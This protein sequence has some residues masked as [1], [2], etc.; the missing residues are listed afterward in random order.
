MKEKILERRPIDCN[1]S[2]RDFIKISATVGGAA[3]VGSLPMVH[4]VL[5]AAAASETYPLSDPDRI[6]YSVCLNCHNACPMK[7]KIQDGVLVKIEGNPY[8][9]Q[10]MLVPLPETTALDEAARSDGPICPKGQAGVQ[11]LY[12]PY[13][14]RRV[15]KRTGKR[16]E[17]KWEAIDFNQAVDEIVSGGN[18]FG[19]GNIPGLEDIYKL[20]DPELANELKGDASAVARGDLTLA[21]FQ[22]KHASHMDLLVDPNHPDL[23]PVN[24][25]FVFLGGRMEHG[26]KELGK[27]FTYNGFGSTNFFLHTTICEQSHHIAYRMMS[28]NKTHMKPDIMNSEFIIYFGTSPFEANFGP[29]NLVPK[30]TTSM[31]EGNLKMAVIDPRLSKTAAKAWK[32]LAPKPGTDAAIALGMI[33]WILENERYDGAFLAAPNKDTANTNDETN[34]SNAT[35]L[36]R[37]DDMTFLKPEDA[38]LEVPVDD[39]GDPVSSY[40]VMVEGRPTLSVEDGMA[41]LFVDGEVNDI[42][43]KSSL[44]LLKDRAMERSVQEYADIAGIRSSDITLLAGEFTSHGKRAVAD[45]YRGPVQHTNGYY[46]GQAIITLNVLIGNTDWKGGLTTGGSHWHED[47]SK[48]GA[49]FPKSMVVG[50]PGGMPHWG[51]YLNRERA[52]YEK[53]TL[54]DGYPAKRPW[55]PFTSELYQNVIPSA[56]AR[57][58]YP[59][60][61]M[62]I[63]KGSPVLASPAGHAQIEML[64]DPGIIPLV[65]ACDIVVGE[66]SMY[67]DYIIPDQTFLERWG[68]PH[69]SPDVVTK[70]SKVRQPLVGPLTETTTV[71]GE[72]MPIGMDAFLIAVG[73]KLGLAG[74]GKDALGEGYDFDR[75]EHYYLAMCANLAFGDKEDG[76]EQLPAPTN[77]EMDVFR[78]AH[79]H[80]PTSIYDEDVWQAAVP[81]ELWP[82]VVT[83]IN[84]GGRYE[85][86]D[87][88]YNGD[89]MA[90]QWKGAW[91]LY[92]ANV[93]KAKHSMTGENFDGLPKVEPVLDAAGKEVNDPGYDLTLITY[94]EV[95]GGQSRTHGAHWMTAVLPENF[96]ALNSID[97]SRMGLE[98]GDEARI[99]SPT[100]DRSFNLGDGRDYEVVGRVKVMEGIRPGVAAVS[101]SYG[102]WAYGSND[103]EINGDTIKGDTIR[104]SGLVPNPAMRLDPVL[105]DVC[106]TD[107]IGG[108]ASFYDTRIRLEK[109]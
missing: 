29:T 79:A 28:G 20:T 67:A 37:L 63:N 90:H 47:G 76:S 11:V 25:Q 73:K 19:E 109:V 52:T 35:F 64:R 41:D 96:I 9:P 54:F 2:R 104:A 3:L 32:W 31:V 26:R 102:H 57:Y 87:K 59:I 77:E 103:V 51:V 82:S 91:N 107:P 78:A 65:V 108:S 13:R 30:L 43:V 8:S 16:G 80:L 27:R 95:T 34:F 92:V 62:F 71:D 101:W 42:P 88:A 69:V 38:G 66:T 94:K 93:A 98:T 106:L 100:L 84:H 33:R 40:V 97:A 10:N 48:A 75:P 49:P 39:N 70:V 46:N 12:D 86:V 61:A 99:I 85:E 17:N 53:S 72:E 55:Y 18:H 50:A 105:G 5:A 68:I 81:D 58:P 36:V 14:I 15:L 89:K 6:L 56:A 45:F 7:A 23:G 22:D 24:N 74:F 21:E 83:L 4:N 1:L 60:K 44:Q